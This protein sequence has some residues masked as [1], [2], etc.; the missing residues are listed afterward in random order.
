MLENVLTYDDEVHSEARRMRGLFFCLRRKKRTRMRAICSR[1]R[2]AHLFSKRTNGLSLKP[3]D[4]H[5]LRGVNHSRRFAYGNFLRPCP[6]RGDFFSGFFFRS[7]APREIMRLRDPPGSRAFAFDEGK[8][9][10]F[11]ERRL[12]IHKTALADRLAFA[13]LT[14]RSGTG[15]LQSSRESSGEFRRSS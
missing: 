8:R 14:S 1:S 13:K 15:S 12:R 9:H 10:L 6:A 4:R 2:F 3:C 7:I 11:V 5:L